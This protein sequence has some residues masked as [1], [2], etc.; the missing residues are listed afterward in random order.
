MGRPPNSAGGRPRT[1]GHKVQTIAIAARQTNDTVEVSI[2]VSDGSGSC[3]IGVTV[4][5][6]EETNSCLKEK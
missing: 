5:G 4:G 3:A 6:L 2:E 1:N